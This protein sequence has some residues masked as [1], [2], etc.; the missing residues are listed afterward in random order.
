MDGYIA[1]KNLYIR[2]EVEKLKEENTES[3][4]NIS[5][6]TLDLLKREVELQ[7]S[8][9]THIGLQL[10]KTNKINV[11]KLLLEKKVKNI[12]TT[13]SLSKRNENPE[14]YMNYMENLVADQSSV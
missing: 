8:E 7:T 11:E 14:K 9:T 10:S 4:N 12:I 2:R 1:I 3:T 13:E 5:P 6:E